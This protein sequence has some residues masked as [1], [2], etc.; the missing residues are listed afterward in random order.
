MFQAI[1]KALLKFAEKRI[2]RPEIRELYLR[3]HPEERRDAKK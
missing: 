3:H 2:Y 1:K